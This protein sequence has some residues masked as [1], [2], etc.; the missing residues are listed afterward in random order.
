[1]KFTILIPHYKTG[2]MTAYSV[3]QILKYKGNHEI[4]ILVIDNNSGDGSA[5][6]LMPFM[7]D[8]IIV[9]YPKD[10][11]Q[12]HGVAFD[13]VLPEVQAEWFITMESDSFPTSETFFDTMELVVKKGFD[14]A[15]SLL[16][17]SGGRYKH[18]AGALYKK[19]VWNEAKDYFSNIPY[20]YYPN[21][22][23]RDNFPV[24][25]MIHKSL[26]EQVSN[27]PDDWVEL[28]SEYKGNTKDIMKEKL[29]YYSPI[30]TGVFHNGIGGRQE[31]FNT[32]GSR[33]EETDVAFIMVGE[34]NTKIIG[35][36]GYEPGQALHYFELAT[37][38]NIHYVPTKIAWLPGK[39]N[40]QQERTVMINGFTHLWGISAY[41]NYT[42]DNAKDI[43]LIKQ[44]IPD[45]LYNTLPIH[46]KIH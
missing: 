33:T 26:V 41:H 42:P 13:Y 5:A 12:S 8:I 32:Y 31:N 3:A 14:G 44:S 38:R 36:M 39:E 27:N 29:A 2:M 43:A 45:Q 22:M 46:Q 16:T 28:A 25:A 37:G 35:R 18:P 23:M 21:F 7:K 40:Q 4:D 1:M 19:S 34:K 17:L 9:E 10:K 6:Y 24:H 11:L 15:G 30:G 20:N